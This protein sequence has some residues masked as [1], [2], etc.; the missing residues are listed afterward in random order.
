LPYVVSET[1]GHFLS[2]AN[3]SLTSI[4]QIAA[5]ESQG[6]TMAAEL[7]ACMSQLFF[8]PFDTQRSK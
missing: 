7:V 6:K 2:K 3:I 5:K 4:A 8:V 1:F